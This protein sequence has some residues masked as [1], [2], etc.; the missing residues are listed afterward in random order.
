MTDDD[1]ATPVADSKAH[2]WRFVAVLVASLLLAVA[3]PVTCGLL[4]QESSFDIFFSL[5]V[6]AVLFLVFEDKGLRRTA[7]ALGLLSLSS[8][9]AGHGVGGCASQV[10]LVTAHLLAAAVFVLALYGIVRVVLVNQ[11]SAGAMF[12]AICGYLLLGIIWSLAYSAL[13]T[14]RP[15]SFHAS[16]SAG[17]NAA[18]AGLDFGTF[19]YFSFVTLVTLGYGDVTP[20]TP[21]ARML[22]WVEAITGQFYLA[23]LVAGL[24]GLKISQAL[25][26]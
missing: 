25:K 26:K 19:N 4:D 13:E 14:A 3:Q 20:V 7:M 1:R 12:G 10:L 21:V 16:A 8:V 6:I 11:A 5:L 22:A 23:I 24:V 18:V 2:R 9:A 15:G 17:G